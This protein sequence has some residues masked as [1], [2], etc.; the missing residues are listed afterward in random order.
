MSFVSKKNYFNFEKSQYKYDMKRNYIMVGML[1]LASVCLAMAG[2]LW[3]NK[4]ATSKER[5][6]ASVKRS[7]V[8]FQKYFNGDYETAKQGAL[9][10][11]GLLDRLSAESK[12][13][14]RNPYASDALFWYIR[15]A[16]LADRNHHPI[17]KAAY[18]QEALSRHKAI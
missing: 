12:D 4:S 3:M 1:F 6:A 10:Q 14:V 17:E 5:L 15:L 13:P 11:I 9:D 8:A 16:K 18:M 7:D 2:Y